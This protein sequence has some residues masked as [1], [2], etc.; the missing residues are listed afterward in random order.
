[1]AQVTG[2]S[3]FDG[4]WEEWSNASLM[5]LREAADTIAKSGEKPASRISSN[6]LAIH[7]LG[8]NWRCSGSTRCSW[9][10]STASAWSMRVG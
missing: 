1:M 8:S 2:G 10:W 5:F 9:P 6:R 3:D 4:V 7:E